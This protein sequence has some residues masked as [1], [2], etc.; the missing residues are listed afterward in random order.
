MYKKVLAILLGSCFIIMSLVGCKTTAKKQTTS[1]TSSPSST[2]SNTTS[3]NTISSN[4]T[5]ATTSPS[6]AV[7]TS[8]SPSSTS[9]TDVKEYSIDLD[10]LISKD[11][12]GI[13]FGYVDETQWLLW[14]FNTF[15]FG[16]DPTKSLAET[17]KKV[18]F[19]VGGPSATLVTDKDI[20]DV[21]K[22]ENRNKKHHLK[23]V[24]SLTNQ[25]KTYIDETLIDTRDESGAAY[26]KLGFRQYAGADTS[27]E[28][29]YDN[30]VIKNT[31]NNQ[32]IYQN[33][34]NSG[35]NPFSEGEIK[36]GTLGDDNAL[37]M[38]NLT[39]T[40]RECVLP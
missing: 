7:T 33:D 25:I 28:A 37:F 2:I 1:P 22:W 23:I 5:G 32:I 13:V 27:E 39:G 36:K 34:F 35:V 29:Y 40:Y 4:T 38:S 8:T 21:I 17:D 20:S 10:F 31:A 18:Y 19:R 26:G 30:I 9:T 11:A 14:Q 3:S 16:D 12:A 24:V 15:V 6:S